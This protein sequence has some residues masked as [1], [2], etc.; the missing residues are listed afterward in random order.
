MPP[1]YTSRAEV[2]SKEELMRV[3]CK[4]RKL[5]EL[6]IEMVKSGGKYEPDASAAISGAGAEVGPGLIHPSIH[7]SIQSVSGPVH[8][9]P[10][11]LTL[12][13]TSITGGPVPASPHSHPHLHLHHRWSRKTLTLHPWPA[14]PAPLT[15]TCAASQVVDLM[16]SRDFLTS[17]S[18]EAALRTMLTPGSQVSK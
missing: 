5:A 4:Q 3:H 2:H 7:S 15:L 17:E 18:T 9:S 8:A 6:M 12:S 13:C 1:G 16:G 11:T 10:F 14:N